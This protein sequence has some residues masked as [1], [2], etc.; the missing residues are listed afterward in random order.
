MQSGIQQV[1]LVF[2]RALGKCKFHCHL[3]IFLK[4]DREAEIEARTDDRPGLFHVSLGPYEEKRDNR[5]DYALCRE[6]ASSRKV[7]ENL[8]TYPDINLDMPL[9]PCLSLCP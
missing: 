8:R 5:G 4:P 7:R 9:T 1:F 6:E 2:C 3:V